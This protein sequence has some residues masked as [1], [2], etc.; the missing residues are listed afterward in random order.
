MKPNI[1]PCPSRCGGWIEIHPQGGLAVHT[2]HRPLGISQTGSCP[3]FTELFGVQEPILVPLPL[4]KSLRRSMAAG[5]SFVVVKVA[6]KNQQG[7]PTGRRED[8]T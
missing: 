8:W 4:V 2:D 1:H 7:G 5:H 6:T 3:S